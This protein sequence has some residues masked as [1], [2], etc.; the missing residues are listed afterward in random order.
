VE[1]VTETSQEAQIAS[2][3]DQ[4]EAKKQTLT[5]QMNDAKDEE[6][7]RI[8]ESEESMEPSL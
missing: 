5:R 4:L 6:R 7:H 8:T 2:R 1:R 3:D